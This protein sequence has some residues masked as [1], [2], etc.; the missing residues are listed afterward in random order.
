MTA[1][2]KNGVVAKMNITLWPQCELMSFLSTF[3]PLSH[4]QINKLCSQWSV[5]K[6]YWEIYLFI[7]NRSEIKFLAPFVGKML[8]YLL[9]FFQRE[10]SSFEPLW[11]KA[12]NLYISY[13]T[14]CLIQVHKSK[15]ICIMNM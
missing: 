14:V 6:E 3:T 4:T 5:W 12:D 2:S 10:S 1:Y 15:R 8:L 9:C 7:E 11:Y 13:S